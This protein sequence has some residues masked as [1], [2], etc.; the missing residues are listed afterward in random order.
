[1]YSTLLYIYTTIVAKM[2]VIAVVK[3]YLMKV[4]TNISLKDFTTMKLG[5]DTTYLV[6]INESSEISA[7]YADDRFRALPK[8]VLGGGSNT[9]ATDEQFSGVVIH[10]ATGGIE[11]IDEDIDSVVFRVAAGEIW[12]DFVKMSVER[13]LSGIEALSA[14]PG[15]VG[16]SPV[17]NI[18]A[19]GQEVSQT[20]T[21]LEAYDTK[22]DSFVTLQNSDCHFSYRSS[23]FRTS[24]YQRYIITSVNFKLLKNAQEKPSYQAVVDALDANGEHDYSPANI[25]KVV[26][27]IR[28]SKLPDP[29]L[30][31]NT[32]SFFKNAIISNS[33][34][35]NLAHSYHTIPVYPMPGDMHKISTGWLIEQ[36]GFKGKLLHGIRVHN[37][38]ALVLIN[39]SASSYADLVAAR[40]EITRAVQQK[41]GITIEQEP[42]ILSIS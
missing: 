30:L 33:I 4:H 15:T 19:Y 26:T 39:E 2:I 41:F 40:D 38:N 18:G 20:I 3:L 9:L 31:P 37:K 22:T 5:G 12:D 8:Y 11:Q 10:I 42:L 28:A 24:A 36:A 17:Q 27:S 34:Y 32:G 35:N 29:L 6:E 14:I 21:S 25:R 13:N 7:L 23:I 16:A 1:M